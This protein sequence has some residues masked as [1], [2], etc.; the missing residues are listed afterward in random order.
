MTTDED[1]IAK[2]HAA[3]K[4]AMQQGLLRE[5]HKHCLAILQRDQTFAD[6]WFL[7]GIIAAHNGQLAKA[8]E[9][10]GNAI[11]LA[12]DNPEYRTELGKQLIVSHQPE[13][14]LREAET[15]LSLDPVQLPTLNTL[16]TVFSHVG[17]HGKALQCFSRADRLLEERVWRSE[18][19]PARV[20]G[21][22][23][24]Q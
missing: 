4:K 9:I 19:L 10:L 5:A 21:G 23:L 6:A 1:A 15:A 7:C 24:F 8:V 18:E 3:A 11:R 13:W 20:A 22:F 12:P 14:A 2:D 17:E 16:G